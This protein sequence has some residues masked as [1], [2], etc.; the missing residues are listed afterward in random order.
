[1]T[2]IIDALK[3]LATG[4]PVQQ[5]KLT[6]LANDGLVEADELGFFHITDA[7]VALLT[8]KDTK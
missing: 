6:E 2:V 7:G 4:K 3:R 1:M 5:R 8:G